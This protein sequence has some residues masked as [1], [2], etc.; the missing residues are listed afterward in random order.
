MGLDPVHRG[1]DVVER[2]RQDR[3]A[4]VVHAEKR[5]DKIVQ[6]AGAAG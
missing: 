3:V 5:A 6:R 1:D 2:V 4:A